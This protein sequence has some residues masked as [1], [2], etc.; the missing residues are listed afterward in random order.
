VTGGVRWRLLPL[1]CLAVLA[2]CGGGRTHLTIPE[3]FTVRTV[4]RPKLSI[5][6]PAAWRSVAT[7]KADAPVKL[8][9]ALPQHGRRLVTNMNV[10][11]TR[12]PSGLTFEQMTKTEAKQLEL[13]AGAKDIKQDVKT[14]PAGRALRLTYRA[15]TNAV[16]HQY[17]VRRGDLLYVLTYTTRA[18]NGERY[19]RTFEQSAHTFEVG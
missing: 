4:E 1:L 9:G 15:R 14:L 13:G 5:A 11:E 19:A 12:V 2:G 8:V 6:L 3:G 18:G 16:V 10:V 7:N 17:F